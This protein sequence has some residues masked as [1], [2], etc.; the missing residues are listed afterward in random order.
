MIFA[1]GAFLGS[2]G[3]RREESWIGR[4][5]ERDSGEAAVFGNVKGEME[6]DDDAFFPYIMNISKR[7]FSSIQFSSLA[8][9]CLTL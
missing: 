9:S 6:K 3:E 8:Q 5:Q 4:G 1:I 2:A 7:L